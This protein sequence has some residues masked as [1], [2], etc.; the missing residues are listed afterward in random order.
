M[1]LDISK[2]VLIDIAATTAQ[3]IGGIDI[4]PAP[5]KASEM[6]GGVRPGAGPRRPRALK[7][8]REGA[9]VSV[10]IG[11]TIEYGKNLVS[12]SQS[13]QRAIT[14]NIELMTGLKVRAVNVTVQGLMLPSAVAGSAVLAN[15]VSGSSVSGSTKDT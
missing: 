1:E 6:L 11:L 3:R 13:V 7:V 2:T 12:V 9:N 15:A 5:I 4:A 8:T 14:E 10:D